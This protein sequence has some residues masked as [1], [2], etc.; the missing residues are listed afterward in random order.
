VLAGD[1][2]LLGRELRAPF[3]IRLDELRSFRGAHV[4]AFAV[5][6]I[7][8]GDV[9]AGTERGKPRAVKAE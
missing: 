1:V 2:I 6:A 3:G 7:W 8:P 9:E 5:A 4:L